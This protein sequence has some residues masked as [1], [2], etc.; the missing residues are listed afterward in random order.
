[1]L[2]LGEI[3]RERG[4]TIGGDG[5]LERATTMVVL[6]WSGERSKREREAEKSD[7]GW[8]LFLIKEKWG[9]GFVVAP[10]VW[11]KELSSV[12]L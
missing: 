1:M 8:V 3:K 6:V 9:F 11:L 4:A 12:G 2:T 5:E 10:C 7:V